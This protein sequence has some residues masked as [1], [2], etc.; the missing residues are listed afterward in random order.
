MTS[1]IDKPCRL[2]DNYERLNFIDEGTYGVVYRAREKSTGQVHALKLIKCD[3]DKEGFPLT[4]LREINTLFS[5]SHVN[6]IRLLEV[7][8]SANGDSFYLVMEYAANDLSGLIEQQEDSSNDTKKRFSTAELKSLMQQLLTGI[9]YLHEHSIIHRDLKL[10]NLLLT[11]DGILKI[12]DFGLCRLIQKQPAKKLTPGCV[13]LWYRAPEV[14][15]ASPLYSFPID[16]WAVGCIFVE[17]LFHKPFLNGKSE[18]DQISKIV[19]V[20]GAPSDNNWS[21]FSDLPH[22]KRISFRSAPQHSSLR[23]TLINLAKESQVTLPSS[24]TIDLISQ[25]LQYD[26][27][28]RITAK[29]ALKHAYFSELP[30]AK[31]P[32]L[33]QTFPSSRS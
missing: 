6:I 25:M 33:I 10:S 24:N 8:T 11:Q 7:V 4:T 14:L 1:L 28:K 17:L 19:T 18:I 22:A 5:V 26:P 32:S 30:R 12:A 27:T 15:M 3:R 23:Q 21:G 20:L 31:H 9:A 16:I 2:A 13:T 29:E